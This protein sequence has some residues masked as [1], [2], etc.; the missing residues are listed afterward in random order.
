M[1]IKRLNQKLKTFLRIRNEQESLRLE[2]AQLARLN[3]YQFKD[4]TSEFFFNRF[5]RSDIKI[6]DTPHFQFASGIESGDQ[7]LESRGEAYYRDYLCASWGPKHESLFDK[8]VVQFRETLAYFKQYGI[9]SPVILTRLPTDSQPY[10]ADGN[11]RVSM[12]LALNK[13]IDAY[14]WPADLVFLKFSK[15]K[16]F[17]GTNNSMPYQTLT[18]NGVDV[19]Q[20]RRSDLRSRLEMLPKDIIQNRSILDVACNVGM[21]LLFSRSIGASKCLGLELSQDMVDIAARFAMF[22]G[23]RTAIQYRQ[24]DIDNDHLEKN[25]VV[26]T[27]FMFSIH[28]HLKHPEQ[29]LQIAECNVRKHVVFEGHPD[30]N[31]QDYSS[32]LNSGIFKRVTELGRLHTSRKK[33]D[34]SRILWLCEK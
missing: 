29:L 25:C 33:E 14:L 24:F 27:A 19:V 23:E 7:E 22:S 11:H 3:F 6:S 2:P 4:S 20:G 30:T 1:L 16:G 31:L 9:E 13:K 5:H 18:L 17:Y 26:D 10:V 12:A 21:S 8:R 32:F 34:N 15:N 28:N